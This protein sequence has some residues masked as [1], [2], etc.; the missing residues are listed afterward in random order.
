MAGRLDDDYTP[1]GVAAREGRA[2]TLHRLEQFGWVS[3][4]EKDPP[5]GRI[6]VSYYTVTHAGRVALAEEVAEAILVLER[7]LKLLRGFKSK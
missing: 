5:R 7:A 1:L 3:V 2:E 4:E 6:P